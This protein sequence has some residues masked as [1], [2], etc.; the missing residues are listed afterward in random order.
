MTADVNKGQCLI[1]RR[2]SL[3]NFTDVDECVEF[4]PCQNHGSC[5]NVEGS[6]TCNCPN[7][8]GGKNCDTGE[9]ALK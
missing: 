6:Y 8:Y 3:L 9:N 2:L 1:I 4:D 7:G 5:S